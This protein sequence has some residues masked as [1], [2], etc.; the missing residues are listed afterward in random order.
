MSYVVAVPELVASVASD[1]SNIGPGMT[2]AHA[3]AAPACM[4]ATGGSLGK[5]NIGISP[6]SSVRNFS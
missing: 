6:I 4:R 5:Q 2:A 1:P 3:T